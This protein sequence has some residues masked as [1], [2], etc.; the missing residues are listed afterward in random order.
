V[1]SSPPE[2]RAR[3]GSDQGPRGESDRVEA[4]DGDSE[5]A[6]SPDGDDEEEGEEEQEEETE[7]ELV[8]P[9]GQPPLSLYL[10][11]ISRI[12][13]LTRD[14][15]VELAKRVASGDRDAERHMVEANLRLVVR[16][17]RRYANRG[18]P[19]PDLIEEGNL[20]LLRAV[21]KFRWDRG[22]RFSTYATWWIRQA[23]VRALA[24]HARLIRLPVHVEALLAK[25]QR[26]KDRLTRT[27]GRL[28][29]LREIAEDLAVP[30]EHLDGLEDVAAT[31]LSLEAPVG[32][33]MSALKDMLADRSGVGSDVLAALLQ[34]QA[35]LREILDTL[36]PSER[37]VIERRFGLGNEAPMTLEAIG[38]QLGITRERVRQIETAGLRKLRVRLEAR[39]VGRAD[40]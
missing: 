34:E 12:P 5:E 9:A 1:S 40:S 33:G 26:A 23:V 13:L 29:E 24:N 27:L 37:T 22:T 15:E 20:G 18:L 10:R 35:S 31:P 32:E 4:R 39:D 30:V 6:A 21:Q 25:Y 28:P 36:S 8:A 19:L 16:I 7:R 2:D 3:D 11:E 38:Q 14:Q 17:A